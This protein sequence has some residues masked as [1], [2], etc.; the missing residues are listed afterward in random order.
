MDPVLKELMATILRYE[1]GYT[2]ALV[3]D[4]APVSTQ[5]N[6]VPNN[7]SE[8]EMSRGWVCCQSEKHCRD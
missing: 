4:E 3:A 6:E 8:L 7:M 5:S 1:L 2:K